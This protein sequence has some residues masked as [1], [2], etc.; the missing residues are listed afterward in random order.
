MS[1]AAFKVRRLARRV[2]QIYDEAL[3]GS[4]LTVGQFGILTRLRRRRGVGIAELA[5]QLTLDASTLSRL[6]RPLAQQALLDVRPDPDDGRAKLLWLT[7]A[8]A[9]RCR[10][11]HG[12]WEAAQASVSARLGEARLAALR[13]A[14]DDAYEHLG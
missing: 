1:C 10:A 8:G 2:T 4:G 5:Q 14:L 7:D 12:K 9:D 13:F 11:A 3:T 6:I